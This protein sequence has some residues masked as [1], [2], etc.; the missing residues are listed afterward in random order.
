MVGDAETLMVVAELHE[1]IGSPADD[2]IRCVIAALTRRP[3]HLHSWLRLVGPLGR[4]CIIIII[5]III[6]SIFKVAY[7]ANAT[8]RT[9]TESE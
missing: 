4:R 9:T 7:A 6:T 2:A 3:S 8:A 1:L 5:I